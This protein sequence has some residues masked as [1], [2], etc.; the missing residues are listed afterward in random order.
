MHLLLPQHQRT[1]S[2]R[3]C[4]GAGSARSH[5]SADGD[6]QTLG[7]LW[8]PRLTFLRT[9]TPKDA[10]VE[11]FNALLITLPPTL[12]HLELRLW[13]AGSRIGVLG[14]VVTPQLRDLRLITYRFVGP[15]S[16]C[17]LH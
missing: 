5:Q 16:L 6:A 13:H 8:P 4:V 2:C 17:S 1:Q 10:P 15:P 11:D 3:L 9:G 12:T 7:K 14:S